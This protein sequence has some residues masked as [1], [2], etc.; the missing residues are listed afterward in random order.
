MEW[1]DP[2]AITTSGGSLQITLSATPDHG[3]DYQGGMMQTWN[4]F[5]FTG[6]ILEGS[7]SDRLWSLY[8]LDPDLANLSQRDAS[9]RF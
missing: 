1:Y 5:C 9:W 6:G 7:C 4:K 2:V 8:T 3:L